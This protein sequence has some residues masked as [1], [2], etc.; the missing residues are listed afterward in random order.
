LAD[1]QQNKPLPELVGQLPKP[2]LR[3]VEIHSKPLKVDNDEVI[4]QLRA[5]G[6][7]Q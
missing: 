7:I 6:Y 4:E 1:K 3:Q 5:L 2:V